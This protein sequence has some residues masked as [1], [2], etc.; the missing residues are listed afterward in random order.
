MCFVCSETCS[1]GSVSCGPNA[2]RPCIL[3]FGLC[4]GFNDCGDN[5]DE[6]DCGELTT[7]NIVI[8]TTIIT[9][10]TRSTFYGMRVSVPFLK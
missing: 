4:D 6:E 3:V 1:A 9:I 5:S 2:T 7:A 10:I 8:T